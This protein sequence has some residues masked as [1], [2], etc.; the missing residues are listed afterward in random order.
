MRAGVLWRELDNFTRV[1]QGLVELIGSQQQ[2]RQHDTSL[3]VPGLEL[4][5]P[6]QHRVRFLPLFPVLVNPGQ[7]VQGFGQILVDLQRIA[8][9]Q[10]S[11][12]ELA[13]FK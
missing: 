7:T 4:P 13:R 10:F 6:G 1:Q 3:D 2:P 5:H 11:L 8:V 9:F 12:V